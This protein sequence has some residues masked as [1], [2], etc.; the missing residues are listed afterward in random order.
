M[1]LLVVSSGKRL[2]VFFVFAGW[3]LGGAV[4]SIQRAG[5]TS[6]LSIKY[7][8]WLEEVTYIITPKER[9]IFLQ[10]PNDKDRD[11]FISAFW[12]QRD[13]APLTE[14]NEFKE[15]HYR[16]LEYVK[17]NFRKGTPIPP[18]K[19]DRGRIYIILGP[20]RN[21]DTFEDASSVYP[22]IVWFYQGMSK[23]GLPDAFNVVFFKRFGVGD[24]KLYSPT[25]DGPQSLLAHTPMQQLDFREAYR[26]LQRTAPALAR[27]S[28][29]LIPGDP[30][31]GGSLSLASDRLLN[32]IDII[33]RKEVKDEYAEKLLMYKD[34][35]EVEY[36]ANYIPSDFRINVFMDKTGDY[37]AHY[38]FELD[39][40]SMNLI[41][42]RYVTRV[43]V[44]GTISDLEGNIIFQHEKAS[45]LQLSQDQF[46]KVQGQKYS[47]QDMFP[48][49]EGNYRVSLLLKNEASKE[50]TSLEEEISIPASPSL[51][52]SD[53]L[54][55]YKMEKQGIPE[56]KKAFKFQDFQ[57]YPSPQNYF[58]S[59]DE[60]I[61]FFQIFG[62]NQTLK[63]FGSVEIAVLKEGEKL[64]SR[65]R[66]L[67]E[68]ESSGYILEHLALNELTP[69]SYKIK[70]SV[71]DEMKKEIIS[72]EAYFFI[73][74][75]E[76]LPRP[77]I[78]SANLPP[79][80]DPFYDHLRGIQYINKDEQKKALTLLERAYQSRPQNIQYGLSYGEAL[81][82]L[83]R[84]ADVKEVLQP[85]VNGEIYQ[86]LDLLARACHATGD[87][88]KA[89]V[90]YQDFMSHFGVSYPILTLVGDC[91]YRLGRKA[92]ALKAW[93]KSL[94]LNPNQEKIKNL[95]ES[96]KE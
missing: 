92:E 13:P 56:G 35:I 47:F 20:P 57:L 88:E 37:F 41:E 61:L 38:L 95:V 72:K 43:S 27:V 62:L 70:V 52:I 67:T 14:R 8:Q 73:S 80:G 83:K 54:L 50:F 10:L 69:A 93:E 15:E 11:I 34:S 19:T 18:W 16:R 86:A 96:I 68:Y 58:T 28:L 81:F 26:E 59:E 45:D 53:I 90:Y 94:E 44:N 65:E 32:D 82:K 21:I 29:N 64:S 79:S 66:K 17:M 71:V 30:S 22:T 9:K 74:P 33:P 42:D 89:L 55:A 7:V 60:L 36:T 12:K 76:S 5:D 77:W 91:Y 6:S 25:L 49:V 87:F 46:H 39:T 31:A 48:L 84:Y 75:V 63:E 85:L 1:R 51:Q 2:S 40:L 3:I 24:Y 23:Y 4:G 78:N